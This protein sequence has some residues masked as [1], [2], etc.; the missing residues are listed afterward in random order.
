MKYKNRLLCLLAAL[1]VPTLAV[2]KSD[3]GGKKGKGFGKLDSN[4]DEVITLAEA[5]A[6]GAERFIENFSE[7]DADGSGEV[8]KDELRAHFQQR[9]S[10]RKTKLKDMD[11]D[12]NGA[13]SYDE[14]ANAGAEKLV[15]HFEKIDANGD[16]EITRDEMKELRQIMRKQ[17]KNKGEG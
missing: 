10:E 14:A 12:G 8:T 5:E 15:E 9:M 2:A 11:A 7:I 13:I 4:G 17:K 1:I 3:K 6:A 16:G